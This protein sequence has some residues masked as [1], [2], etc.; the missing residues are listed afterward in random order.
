MPPNKKRNVPHRRRPWLD[1]RHPL[2]VTL[3]VAKR[4][5][6][7]RTK[8][9][10]R[11]LRSAFVG[12]LGRFGTRLI[13]YSVQGNHLHLIVEST[14]RVALGR[15]MKGLGVRIAKRLNRM[16][17]TKGQ[18][19]GDRYHARPL[20][21][22]RQVRRGLHYV[23][24]NHRHHAAQRN[25][26]LPPSWLDPFSTARA[27]TGWR[28]ATPELIER[29]RDPCFPIPLGVLAARTDLLKHVW[30]SYGLLEIAHVPGKHS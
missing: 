14:D 21:N 20:R 28:D 17:G 24:N 3:R 10:F 16:M 4:C 7:L 13:E 8:R 25:A 22:G 30:R 18:V 2:H 11:R 29:T 23:L 9:A 19:L 27:F 12:A 1:R 15:A 5:W 6:N 26:T